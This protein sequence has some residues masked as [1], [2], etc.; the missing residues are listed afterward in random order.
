MTGVFPATVYLYVNQTTG[1]VIVAQDLKNDVFQGNYEVSFWPLSL[2]ER[3]VIYL[4]S[5]GVQMVFLHLVLVA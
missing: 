1:E 2:Q 5:K 3:L 4:T